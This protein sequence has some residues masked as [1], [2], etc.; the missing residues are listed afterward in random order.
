MADFNLVIKEHPKSDAVEL[1]YL[2]KGLIHSELREVKEK[3]ASFEALVEKFPD[4]QAAA[5]AWFGIGSGYFD[6]KQFDTAIP[7]LKKCLAKDA[8]AFLDRAS[9]MI[10]VSF[11]LKQDADGLAKAIDEYRE[12][13]PKAVTSPD[14][15]T[16]AGMKLYDKGEFMRSSRFLGYAVE[17][18]G[19][20]NT[21]AAVWNFLGM[22]H[23]ET[24]SWDASVTAMDK[25]LGLTQDSPAKAKGYLTKSRAL[26]GLGKFPEALQ[27]AEE[28]L[29]I[30]K[31]GKIQAQLLIQEGDVLSAEAEGFEKAGQMDVALQKWTEAAGK[32]VVPSQ[33]FVDPEITPEALHKAAI[34]L[35]KAGQ[36]DKARMLRSQLQERY[37][38]YNAKQ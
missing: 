33:M 4:S 36:K 35:E 5:Q 12:A 15:L 17:T 6:Q 10:V 13:N 14:V 23:L 8:K 24:K 28:G 1:A 19:D 29:K 2:Q 18:F 25:Y 31:D 27:A 3:I 21:P 30:V 11:Y 38:N 16:F 32:Y 26:A 22:A 7:A 9:P 37:P 34:A 20:A